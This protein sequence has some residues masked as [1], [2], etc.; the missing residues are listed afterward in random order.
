MLVLMEL[1]ETA[2]YFDFDY[3]SWQGQ[4]AERSARA[5]VPLVM[6]RFRPKSVV[7]IGCGSGAW[8]QVFHEHGVPEVLGVDGPYVQQASLRIPEDR[9]VRHDLSRPFRIDREF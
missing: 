5:V 1:G 3:F 9:F 6:N 8:L 4:S 2:S 7:D